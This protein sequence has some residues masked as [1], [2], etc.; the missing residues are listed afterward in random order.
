MITTVSSVKY[1][2]PYTVINFHLLLSTFKI[3]CLN[4]FQT[5]NEILTIVSIPYLTLLGFIYN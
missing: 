4:S 1:P 3:Y 5:C 2:S